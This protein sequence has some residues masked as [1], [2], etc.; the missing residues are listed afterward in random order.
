MPAN[1]IEEKLPARIPVTEQDDIASGCVF[2]SVYRSVRGK[3]VYAATL[4]AQKAVNQRA[5]KQAAKPVRKQLSSGEDN[6]PLEAIADE[7]EIDEV[8]QEGAETLLCE[9]KKPVPRSLAPGIMTMYCQHG[10]C[11][12]F[13]LL[14]DFESP[15]HVFEVL[16]DRFEVPPKVVFYDRAC[17]LHT[18]IQRREPA[19]YRDMVLRLDTLHALTHTKCSCGYDPRIYRSRRVHGSKDNAVYVNSQICE[20]ENSKLR[21]LRT[22]SAFMCQET[23]L[24][25]TRLFMARRNLEVK[26]KRARLQPRRLAFQNAAVPSAHC[27]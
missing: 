1:E 4:A 3:R 24:K 6:E 26:A 17:Q 10:I 23:F 5:F 22:P 21:W 27:S 2:G 18:Y 8:V 12:G 13:W 16:Y 15:R 20:Q 11:L 9:R 19:A 7:D 25:F 14:K